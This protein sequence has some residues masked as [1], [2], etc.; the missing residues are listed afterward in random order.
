MRVELHFLFIVTK[1][2]QSDDNSNSSDE[3]VNT[4]NYDSLDESVDNYDSFSESD[5]NSE[6][7]DDSDEDSENEDH[8]N[9]P[10][11][12]YWNNGMIN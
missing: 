10:D 6:S 4:H 3:S 8:I 12:D 11:P 1:V 7:V 2:R 5:E 9:D